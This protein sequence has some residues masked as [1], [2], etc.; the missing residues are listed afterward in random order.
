ML[1]DGISKYLS[2]SAE[3]LQKIQV[4][5]ALGKQFQTA[6]DDPQAASFSL[7]LKSAMTRIRSYQDTSNKVSNWLTAG[8]FAFQQMTDTAT[9]ALSLVTAGMNDTVNATTRATSFY[10]QM[11]SFI[12]QA[13]ELANTTQG[14]QYIFSGYKVDQKPFSITY[15]AALNDPITG[16]YNVQYHGDSGAMQRSLNT[17]KTVQQNVTGDTA[18]QGFLSSLVQAREAFKANDTTALQQAMAGLQS[19]MDTIGK[20]SAAN[21]ARMQ[22]VQANSDFLVQSSLETSSLLDKNE[23]IDMAQA[24]TQ[25]RSQETNYQVVMEV[26]SRAISAMSLFDYLK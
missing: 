8:D 7:S 3:A 2:S 22:Q 14:G 26:T 5:V 18:F 16:Q 13:V 4:R 6:S 21:G 25:L 23:N 11:D 24:I 10:Q 17:G 19:S 12:N 20:Q 1:T 15:D 9:K